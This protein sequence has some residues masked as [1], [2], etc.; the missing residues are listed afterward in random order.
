[1]GEAVRGGIARGDASEVLSRHGEARPISGAQARAITP[2]RLE[3]VGRGTVPARE[4]VVTILDVRCVSR[5]ARCGARARVPGRG[6]PCGT[7]MPSTSSESR[8]I[9]NR[10]DGTRDVEYVRP[11]AREISRRPSALPISF[12]RPRPNASPTQWAPIASSRATCRL[13]ASGRL[14][15]F[16]SSINGAQDKADSDRQLDACG[17]HHHRRWRIE[18]GQAIAS[19]VF[20]AA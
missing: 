20:A 2:A 18:H 8:R 12:S 17:C 19:V 3:S 16:R 9:A 11:A 14:P 4:G 10:C 7:P 13:R 1:M 5:I 15:R 6:L